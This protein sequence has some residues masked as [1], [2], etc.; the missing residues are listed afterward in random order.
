M[1]GIIALNEKSCIA[2]DFCREHFLCGSATLREIKR[3][4]LTQGQRT[5]PADV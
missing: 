3:E 5:Q 1:T 2:P 4:V